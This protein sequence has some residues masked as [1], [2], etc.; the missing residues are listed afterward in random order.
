MCGVVPSSILLLKRV[1]CEMK[2]F[3]I[4]ILVGL[5]LFCDARAQTVA[6]GDQS[7]IAI[8]TA[9]FNASY[10]SLMHTYYLKRHIDH[11]TR[12]NANESVAE[13]D[14]TPDSVI[15]GRLARLH[16]V[17]PMTYNE[18]VR[19]Y[20]RTYLKIMSNRLDVMVS[21]CEMYH[22]LFENTLSA[23]GVP[24][25]L[26]YLA[27]VESAMNPQATSRVG[28]AGLWQF[29]YH[30][31]K[32]YD[33]EVNSLVDQRRDPYASTVAAAR[34]L[35]DLNRI[36]NDWTLAIAAYNCGPG[37]INKAISRSGGKTDFWQIYPYL[38]RETRGY[39]PAFIAATY[40]M[41][42]YPE[43][44]IRPNKIAP[45]TR[46]DT[47]TLNHDVFYCYVEQFAGINTEELRTLNPQYRT[48]FVP[49]STGRYSLILPSDKIHNFIQ[50]EDSIYR[51]TQ[52]SIVKKPVQ[53]EIVKEKPKTGR[54]GGR[55]T[56]Y[57]KVK[58]G[59]TLSK[60]AAKYGTTVAQLRKRN[61]LKSDKI[62]V[63][64][65]IRVR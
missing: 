62:R 20:I 21:L 64:Q 53:V 61:G 9:R 26:K 65:R 4:T 43:H 28:A 31:G 18:D 7:E 54:G 25:E 59:E 51:H 16:T 14:R 45:P 48:D 24:E 29:M 55:S 39:I 32:V 60:I 50:S 12:H 38:P 11:S 37:N 52:D 1:D 56:V 41:K 5:A 34:Y 63:G 2:I 15:A 40:V 30:T 22:P 33:L 35:R 42:Y 27:I 3:M 44:G 6:D 13:F 58:Q 49:A 46:F 10:D 17:I 57:H 36:F 8:M 19:A 47:V 23:Y